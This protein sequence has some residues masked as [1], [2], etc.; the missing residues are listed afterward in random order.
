[1][2]HGPTNTR[3]LKELKSSLKLSE[4][5]RKVVIGTTLGDGCLINSWS[6]RAAR[7]QIRHQVK[8]AEYVNWKYQFF[9]GW[10][11]TP[12]RI[13]IYNN[14][15]VFRTVSHPDLMEIKKIFYKDGKRFIPETINKLLADPLSLAIWFMDDGSC[16]LDRLAFKLCSYG[17]REKGNL[18]LSDCLKNNFNLQSVIYHDSK[19]FYLY[20]SKDSAL[21]FYQLVKPYIIECMKYKLRTVNPVETTRW[22]PRHVGMKI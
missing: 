1:M 15:V 12:P 4:V 3:R 7:L 19:G 11:L 17:F 20:F 2:K 10:V 6:G 22:L 14:S 5:Q 8:H 9:N 13:D 21:R 16:Y 18:L